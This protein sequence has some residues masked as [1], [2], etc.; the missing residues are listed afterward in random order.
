[1]CCLLRVTKK[2]QPKK[3]M[4]KLEIHLEKHISLSPPH[5]HSVSIFF[6][7]LSACHINK[8]N[9]RSSTKHQPFKI[10][11]LCAKPNEKEHSSNS[12]LWPGDNFIKKRKSFRFS[13]YHLPPVKLNGASHIAILFRSLCADHTGLSFWFGILMF[14]ISRPRINDSVPKQI[15]VHLSQTD[16]KTSSILSDVLLIPT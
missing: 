9:E 15:N 5:T 2:Q 3:G 16:K 14:H 1:M 7:K 4:A 8:L 10:L 12:C 13:F 6:T 11:F